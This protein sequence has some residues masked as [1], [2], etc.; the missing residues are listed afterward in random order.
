M[1]DV[2][3]VVTGKTS[4]E[5]HKK[6]CAF[7]QRE[8]GAMAW[9]KSHNSAFSVDKF[10]LLN[11]ARVKPGLR[12]A[13][14]LGGTVIEPFNHQHFLGVLLDRCLRFHQHVALAVA[15]GSAWTALIRRLARMQHGLQMEEVRR[16]YMSVAIPSM[17][18]AVDVF[19]VP[20]QTRVGGGQEYGSVGAVKKLTQIHCQAL[21]VMTGAMRSTATD[22]LE[23]HAHVLPFRL[24]MDQLCQR[25]VVRL[26]TLLPSHPLHPH[27]LRASWHY[28]KS[29]RAPLHELMYTYRATA[30]PVGM[31]K[32]QATQRHPCWC[33]PHVTKIT[34]SKDV[35][36]DQQ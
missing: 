28:V 26:C 4:E 33:P 10:G 14:D 29:H 36:L 23:A 27:I 22:V 12:P 20:V 31:E 21:L 35:S 1:D 25:S 15:R 13:L 9:S 16:L 11:C 30:S 34:S 7:M 19:L 3:L 24:L 6:A 17:L 32:V 8:G 18:Y 5:T 2:A